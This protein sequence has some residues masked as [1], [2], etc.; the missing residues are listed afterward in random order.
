MVL[1]F[2][3]IK[4]AG[5]DIYVQTAKARY[6]LSNMEVHADA[7]GK[8]VKDL[9]YDEINTAVQLLQSSVLISPKQVVEIFNANHKSVGGYT[10]MN[11]LIDLTNNTVKW[12]VRGTPDGQ[13]QQQE[14]L[15][16][17]AVSGKVLLQQTKAMNV[18][19]TFISQ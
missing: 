18:A 1:K 3:D 9:P 17:D 13:K 2:A 6:P 19:S 11:L 5:N 4:Q 16:I 12:Q 15:E 7:S 14:L 10:Y 8:M